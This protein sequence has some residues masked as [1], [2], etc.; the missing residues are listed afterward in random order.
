MKHLVALALITCLGFTPADKVSTRFKAPDGY[1]LVSAAPGSFGA[2]LQNLPL[3]PV[4]THTKTY[5]GSIAA[6]DQYTAAVVDMSIGKQDLQ[7]CA[8]A[9]MRLSAEYLYQKQDYKA[10]S[11]NFTSG[12]KCDFVHYANG[13]R[14]SNGR[15]VLKGKKDYSY[16]NFMRYL[17]LVFSYA[18]T[19]SL[20]KELKPVTDANSLQAGDVFIKGGSPGHCF[21]VVGVAENVAHKKIFLLAQS[22]M[23]AQNIQVIQNGSPWFTPG[24]PAN[25]PYGEL[26]DKRYLR[27]F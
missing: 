14:Y 27:R 19:L 17:T 3:L 21:I 23:P 22:F 9:V 6:T 7:Q 20:E 1:K 2:Y 11:F 18:G 8:D 24:Q 10:I 25:I 5:K 4:G 13:Y 15:W 12:F 26:V 16:E